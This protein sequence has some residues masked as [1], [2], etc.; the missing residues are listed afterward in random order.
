MRNFILNKLRRKFNGIESFYAFK[1][2]NLVFW[3]EFFPELK[4]SLWGGD[5]CKDIAKHD[6]WVIAVP[7]PNADQ[8]KKLIEANSH[9]EV[10]HFCNDEQ[11]R[12]IQEYLTR[13]N[14]VVISQK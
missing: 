13:D 1:E 7:T 14:L 6:V 2:R 12:L 10:A 9:K 8:K 11:E 5:I 3:K 4:N